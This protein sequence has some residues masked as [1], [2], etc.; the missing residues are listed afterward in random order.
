MST[1][2]GFEV[3]ATPDDVS[4]RGVTKC[5]YAPSSGKTTP[6]IELKVEWGMAEAAMIAGGMLGKMEQGELTDPLAG[7]GDQ[8]YMVGPEAMIR[9]GEDLVRIM[10]YG[11]DEPVPA[12][13]EIFATAEQRLQ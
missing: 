2:V 3:T 4:S 10:A 7:V 13:K 1:I 9:H 6:M 12:I 11:V 5:G 8:A